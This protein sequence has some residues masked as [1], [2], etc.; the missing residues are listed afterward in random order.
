MLANLE[1]LRDTRLLLLWY[2]LQS[3][4]IEK[5]SCLI[6]HWK[7]PQNLWLHLLQR[8]DTENQPREEIV[9]AE[10]GRDPNMELLFILFPWIH[11][12]CY[13]L[14]AT[15]CNNIYKILPVREAHLNLINLEITKRTREDKWKKGLWYQDHWAIKSYLYVC[16]GII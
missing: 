1:S 16:N 7:Y 9:K 2:Q 14:L 6:I 15:E 3:Q 12:W 4:E 10:S 5:P 8:K 11:E 13:L